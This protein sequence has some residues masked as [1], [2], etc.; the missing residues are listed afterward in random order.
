MR[1]VSDHAKGGQGRSQNLISF[2]DLPFGVTPQ[3]LA[4]FAFSRWSAKRFKGL[5]CK[6]SLACCSGVAADLGVGGMAGDRL[7]LLVGA[8]GFC[9]PSSSGFPKPMSRASREPGGIAPIAHLVAKAGRAERHAAL[10]DDER[11]SIS[12]HGLQKLREV[13]VYRDG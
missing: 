11:Q 1:I 13:P 8:T 3:G 12:R 7:D 10:G 2:G 5:V 9:K 6:K 4:N